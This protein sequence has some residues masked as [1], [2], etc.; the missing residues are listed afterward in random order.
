MNYCNLDPFWNSNK[1]LQVS[2]FTSDFLPIDAADYSDY[3]TLS[4]IGVLATTCAFGWV[5]MDV[6]SAVSNDLDNSRTKSQYRLYCEYIS[7]NDN[8]FDTAVFYM[9]ES[10]GV[11]PQLVI[12]HY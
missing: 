5:E 2:H 10:T 3:T 6:T 11:E 7:D 9:A 4:S 12:R 1:P 8:E